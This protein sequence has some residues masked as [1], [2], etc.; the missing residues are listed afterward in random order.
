MIIFT[1]FIRSFGFA[2]QGFKQTFKEE[3]NMRIHS[4]V[5]ILVIIAGFVFKISYLEWIAIAGCIGV[6]F[7]AEMF[8]TAIEN[9]VDYISLERHPM[10]GKIK[11]L[12][13]SAV[14]V[15][16]IVSVIIGCLIFLPKIF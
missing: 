9:L 16:T 5:A 6:V 1:K 11:D 3:Q 4:L 2:F 7:A 14:L 8:N 12:S 15:C 10:A 13:A